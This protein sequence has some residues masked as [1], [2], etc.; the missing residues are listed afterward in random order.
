[1]CATGSDVVHKTPHELGIGIYDAAV[2]VRDSTPLVKVFDALFEFKLKALPIVD[3]DNVV[4]NVY[5]RGEVVYLARDPM[6]HRLDGSVADAIAAQ[7]RDVRLCVCVCEQEVA[8]PC[9]VACRCH[10]VQHPYSPVL[11]LHCPV[12]GVLTFESLVTCSRSESLLN[13][14][15]LFAKAKARHIGEARRRPCALL[16]LSSHTRTACISVCG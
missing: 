2:A 1:M 13:V 16:I 7:K 5:H 14:L 8:A 9:S 6:L 15:G 3:A 4:V 11:L 12:Q 10:L